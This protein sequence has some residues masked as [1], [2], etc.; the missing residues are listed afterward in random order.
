LVEQE[1]DLKLYT[2]IL[3][4]EQNYGSNLSTSDIKELVSQTQ[5]KI[6][7]I[8]S[9]FNERASAKFGRNQLYGKTDKEVMEMIQVED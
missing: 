8:R 5:L 9:E 2:E 1:R 3:E 6:K 7:A 4:N